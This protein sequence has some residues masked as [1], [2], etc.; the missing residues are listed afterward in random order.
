RYTVMLLCAWRTTD[1]WRITYI[2]NAT[3]IGYFP[4]I[5]F[6]CLESLYTFST[7]IYRPNPAYLYSAHNVMTKLLIWKGNFYEPIEKE[8]DGTASV[9]HFVCTDCSD[10]CQHVFHSR[11]SV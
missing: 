9:C 2:G 11:R 8:V 4:V 6:L 1:R 5:V 3:M 7:I 10:S